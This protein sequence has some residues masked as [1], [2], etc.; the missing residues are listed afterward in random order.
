MNERHRQV[1]AT[2]AC[3]HEREYFESDGRVWC[4][5]CGHMQFIP[6]GLDE[7]GRKL[8]AKVNEAFARATG[9]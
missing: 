6:P 4:L 1:R 3:R 8:D 7:H 9:V 2:Y 5:D